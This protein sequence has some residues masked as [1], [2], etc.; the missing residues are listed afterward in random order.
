[1]P[2]YLNWPKEIGT[3]IKKPGGWD[4]WEELKLDSEGTRRLFT[5]Y[6]FIISGFYQCAWTCS[7]FSKPSSSVHLIFT[8]TS[9]ITLS[10]FELDK[11]QMPSTLRLYSRISGLTVA[12]L[13]TRKPPCWAFIYPLQRSFPHTHTHSH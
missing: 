3:E 11:Q 13:L 9:M 10:I 1:M 8:Q 12:Q 4:P 5:E 7:K 2:T 6:L